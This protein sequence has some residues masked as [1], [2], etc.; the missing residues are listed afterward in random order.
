MASK[1]IA[2]RP[3]NKWRARYRDDAGKEH[4]RHFERKVDAQRWLDEQTTATL[5]GQWVDPQLGKV[6]FGEYALRV[7][8]GP[9][10]DSRAM[11]S[12]RPSEVQQ[13]V[14]DLGADLRPSTVKVI[15]QHVRSVF[16][17]AELDRVIARAPC[18]RITLPKTPK[19]LIE[20]LPTAT[21]LALEEAMPERWRA[22]VRLMAGTGL[23]P[24]EAVAINADRVDFLRRTV[25]VDRQRVSGPI[26]FDPTKTTASVRTVPLPR[27]VIDALAAH[28]AAYPT[29]PD[30]L[31][32]TTDRGEPVDRAEFGRTFGRIARTVGAPIGA[33]S[34]SLRHY[35][36][37]LLIR[38]G[39][40]VTVV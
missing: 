37:S 21:V 8:A 35:D 5:T 4:A 26:R 28:M 39:E 10:F 11:A 9:K 19:K 3:N 40:S 1:N 15:Y 14:V 18:E 24:A 27:V 29:G 23:R 2:K 32:S 13:W 25:T 6:T 22:L 16:R 36:A 33:R 38:H 17:A 30:G 7:H 34:H 20:P 31:L 12:I